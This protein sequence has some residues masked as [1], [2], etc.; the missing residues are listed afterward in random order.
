M[1]RLLVNITMITDTNFSVSAFYQLLK[2]VIA[3]I[4]GS[5]IICGSVIV[6]CMFATTLSNLI[7]KV[8][9][10]AVMSVFVVAL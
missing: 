4:S 5:Y 10:L 7:Y 9:N 3:N 1:L 8:L 6:M 2:F